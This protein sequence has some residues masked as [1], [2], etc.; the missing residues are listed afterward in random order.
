MNKNEQLKDIVFIELKEPMVIGTI[1]IPTIP[2]PVRLTSL[3]TGIKSGDL[4]EN[5]NLLRVTEGIVYLLGI[6]PDFKYKDEYR[7]IIHILNNPKDYILALAKTYYDN[8]KLDEARTYLNAESALLDSDADVAFTKLNIDEE[9]FSL[10][11]EELND[12]ER[13]AWIAQL[14]QGYEHLCD[15]GY[16][17]AY[18]KLGYIN[19]NL[20]NELK[21]YLYFKKFLETTDNEELK[22]DVRLLIDD[23]KDSARMEEAET[24]LS[25][26][27]FAQAASALD[28][29]SASYPQLDKLYYY[30]SLVAY[31]GGQH[32][33]A[34]RWVL[35]ALE[36]NK[37]E[38]YYNQKAL[39]LLSVG[40]NI[41][42]EDT[43]REGIATFPSSYT[44]LYNLG[45][46][47]INMGR[48]DGI[49]YLKQANAI[50]PS[51]TLAQMIDTYI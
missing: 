15:I 40:N 4:E 33:E 8:D 23:I 32:N 19:H 38:A 51:D 16:T 34:L 17:L 7:A 31:N 20:G 48:R 35:Q 5:F 25:Y 21:A 45:I 46:L 6:E 29:V 10:R 24:Y 3:V 49:D 30:K 41:A 14:V 26:G 12:D 18:Y 9:L 37:E 13:S 1:T 39:I 22:N 11:Q 44:M 28:E 50:E 27:K 47:L 42:A 36:L 43:Y 2:L